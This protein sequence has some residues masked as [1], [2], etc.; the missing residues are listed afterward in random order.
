MTYSILNAH[1]VEIEGTRTDSLRE[2][3]AKW[4]KLYP[5]IICY[6]VRWECEGCFVVLEPKK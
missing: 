4:Q 6:L 2:A 5:L 3:M 1:R